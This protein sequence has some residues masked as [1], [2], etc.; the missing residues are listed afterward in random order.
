[1]FQTPPPF[2]SLLHLEEEIPHFSIKVGH[3]DRSVLTLQPEK[4]DVAKIQ[5]Y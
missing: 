1:M 2:T 4:H 5:F 3:L